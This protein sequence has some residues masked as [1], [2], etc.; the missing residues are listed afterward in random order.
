MATDDIETTSSSGDEELADL[1]YLK[2]PSW[3]QKRTSVQVIDI[4]SPG[5]VCC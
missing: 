3:N 5:K 2:P 1:S 4:Q